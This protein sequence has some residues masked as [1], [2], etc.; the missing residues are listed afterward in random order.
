MKKHGN[1]ER[2][3]QMNNRIITEKASFFRSAARME[4]KG[5]WKKAVLAMAV[6]VVIMGIV[7]FLV[8]AFFNN[9]ATQ[10]IASLYYVLVYGPASVG[11]I[12]FFL[13]LV[14]RND[15]QMSDCF[16]GFYEFGK[17]FLLGLLLL[18][19]TTLWTFLFI[20]PGIIAA[21]R[22][23]MAFMIMK[24]RPDLKPL[25]CIRES[26]RI[27]TGNKMRKF[28]LD[29]SFIG[30]AILAVIP[31]SIIIGLVAGFYPDINLVAV[32]ILSVI[33][34]IPILWVSAYQQTADVVF[35]E[36]LN[37]P[38]FKAG[39]EYQPYNA[40]TVYENQAQEQI[41]DNTPQ[42]VEAPEAP[43]AVEA[44]EAV[45]EGAPEEAGNEEE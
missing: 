25:E 8:T 35:Y 21:Y 43:K 39:Y 37:R 6:Y 5:N 36:E 23:S 32:N 22:Y 44:P 40:E 12:A 34:Y 18:L 41:A 17:S 15:P 26:K 29:I 14:R 4:L 28:C 7:N 45:E 38:V 27:M 42:A 16:D 20:I 24:D 9:P 3:K 33:L 2:E 11:I 1:L 30:W 31:G 13:N 10:S 19:F